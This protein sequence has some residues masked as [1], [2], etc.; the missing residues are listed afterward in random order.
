MRERVAAWL[1]AR[2][3]LYSANGPEEEEILSKT[4]NALRKLQLTDKTVLAVYRLYLQLKIKVDEDQDQEQNQDQEQEKKEGREEKEKQEEGIPLEDICEQLGVPDL[5]SKF[6]DRIFGAFDETRTGFLSF[7]GFLVAYWNFC[8]LSNYGV[9]AHAVKI[10]EANRKEAKV[11]VHECDALIRMVHDVEETPA[12]LR[13]LCMGLGKGG[14]ELVGIHELSAHCEAIFGPVYHL[15]TSLRKKVL[16]QAFWEEEAQRRVEQ[17]GETVAT[18]E[19]LKGKRRAS[20]GR[21]SYVP[22]SHSHHSA[23]SRPSTKSSSVV[24]AEEEE[25]GLGIDQPQQS[26]HPRLRQRALTNIDTLEVG[27]SL[28]FTVNMRDDLMT[29]RCLYLS[30]GAGKRSTRPSNAM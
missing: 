26:A 8:T 5:R 16:G 3:N 23:S 1:C 19:I 4:Q 12:D 14:Q 24:P 18:E 10:F 28:T 20:R 2:K 13:E 7:R 30:R 29:F 9:A 21:V 17:F 15:Q 6:V 27:I 22:E 11:T 25:D